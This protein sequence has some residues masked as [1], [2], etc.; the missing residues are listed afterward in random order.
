MELNYLEIDKILMSSGT[1]DA[2]F[3]IF[4]RYPFENILHLAISRTYIEIL[5][6]NHQEL[7]NYLIFTLKLLDIIDAK[8]E[9]DFFRP[10]FTEIT[11]CFANMI[12]VCKNY[13][14]LIENTNSQKLFDEK[15]TEINKRNVSNKWKEEAEVKKRTPRPQSL[16]RDSFDYE[17]CP[18]NIVSDQPKKTFTCAYCHDKAADNSIQCPKCRALTYCSRDC[19]KKHWREGHSKSC[20]S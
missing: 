14:K 2:L 6:N 13:T 15:L 9:D 4:V 10:H 20:G 11:N 7:R 18:L 12:Q 8:I 17:H 3:R 19:Q 1:M 16:P 5:Q